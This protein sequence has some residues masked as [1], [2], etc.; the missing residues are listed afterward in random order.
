[1]HRLKFIENHNIQTENSIH[2]KK[3][4][5]H[6]YPFCASTDVLMAFAASFTSFRLVIKYLFSVD[7][8]SFVIL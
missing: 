6:K 3:A 8:P 5:Y 1:M 2:T 4:C 7:S